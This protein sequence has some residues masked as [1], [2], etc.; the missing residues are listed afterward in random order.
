ML[1][2]L[3]FLGTHKTAI[4]PLYE[5]PGAKTQTI[6]YVKYI[7]SMSAFWKVHHFFCFVFLLNAVV[8]HPSQLALGGP[9]RT[10]CACVCWSSPSLF[11]FL[12]RDAFLPAQR[13]PLQLL[14]TERG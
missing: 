13:K 9:M 10:R 4:N 1:R 11:L 12:R 3:I 2:C 7:K 8:F 6:I 14:E 5:G